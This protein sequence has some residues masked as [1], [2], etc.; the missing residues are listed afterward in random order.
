MGTT[1]CQQAVCAAHNALGFVSRSTYATLRPPS[2]ALAVLIVAE[3]VRR[4]AAVF[5]LLV[6][7]VALTVE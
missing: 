2:R 1:L 3:R 6:R 5:R 7:V 4:S